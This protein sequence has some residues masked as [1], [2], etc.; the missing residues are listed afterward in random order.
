[1][2]LAVLILVRPPVLRL[3]TRGDGLAKFV[4]N[5]HSFAFMGMYFPFAQGTRLPYIDAGMHLMIASVLRD[6]ARF[7]EQ[8][9]AC[10]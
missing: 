2:S 7:A 4:H 5:R 10:S 3:G 6:A 1:M 8:S 9:Q